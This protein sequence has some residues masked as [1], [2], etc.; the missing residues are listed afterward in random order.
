MG[1]CVHVLVF[2][3]VL[4][5]KL[6]PTILSRLRKTHFQLKISQFFGTLF[7]VLPG[8]Q[9]FVLLNVRETLLIFKGE[10][11]PHFTMEAASSVF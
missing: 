9:M 6:L 1:G 8:S 11:L 3:D 10:V 7:F 2:W 5:D 4:K